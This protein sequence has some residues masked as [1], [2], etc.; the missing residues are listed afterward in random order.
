MKPTDAVVKGESFIE[1]T[2]LSTA[3]G[4]FLAYRLSPRLATQA[5]DSYITSILSC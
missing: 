4:R 2:S 5:L 3:I 1:L